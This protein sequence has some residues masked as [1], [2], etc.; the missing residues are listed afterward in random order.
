M[1]NRQWGGLS[2]SFVPSFEFDEINQNKI[3]DEVRKFAVSDDSIDFFLNGL[4]RTIEVYFVIRDENKSNDDK[5]A[6]ISKL[7]KVINGL[8]KAIEALN[9][10]DPTTQELFSQYAYL[11]EKDLFETASVDRLHSDPTEE[12]AIV[13]EAAK[14]QLQE[15]KSAKYVRSD[16]P[17]YLVEQ[18]V[19]KWHRNI[20]DIKHYDISAKPWRDHQRGIDS[21]EIS[22]WLVVKTV[23]ECGKY[24]IEDPSSYIIETI[25]QIGE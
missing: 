12:L 19:K 13:L 6:T 22:L 1:A 18:V 16:S 2:G 4:K 7:T 25:T 17:R 23:L 21:R 14:G 20:E 24:P 8:E 11:A 5:R 9:S 3:T 15:I 10:L